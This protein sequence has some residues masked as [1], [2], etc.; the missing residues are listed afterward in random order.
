MI[1]LIVP[2][3]LIS[4]V[5]GLEAWAE[6]VSQ[7]IWAASSNTSGAYYLF[8]QKHTYP[9]MPSMSIGEERFAILIWTAYT[10]LGGQ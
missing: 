8:L 3:V 9:V 2:G 1:D 4:D 5:V 10:M 7:G 6:I